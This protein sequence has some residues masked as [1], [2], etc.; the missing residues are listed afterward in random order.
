MF[1]HAVLWNAGAT[2][3][4]NLGGVLLA[5]SGWVLGIAYAINDAGQLVGVGS[6][7]GAHHGFRLTCS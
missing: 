1:G 2:T 5:G 6:I 3:P 4:T 7:N